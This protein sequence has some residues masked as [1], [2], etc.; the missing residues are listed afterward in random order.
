VRDPKRREQL[1]E[2]AL[3]RFSNE[4]YEAATTRSIAQEAGVTEA[5]LFRHFPTKRA[6]FLTVVSDFGPQEI[7]SELASHAQSGRPAIDVLRAMVTSYLDTTWQHL[8]WLRVLFQ[9]ARRD[10]EAAEALRDQYQVVRR[11]LG[12]VVRGAVASGELRGDKAEAVM[13]VTALALRGFIARSATR[14][15]ADWDA[16]RDEFVADL[17]TVTGE[18]LRARAEQ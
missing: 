13:Q 15:P 16:A 3:R 11:A 4:G 8:A 7:F 2:A 18:S 10:P 1:L 12:D 5:V 6:L 14:P 9:E 17:I